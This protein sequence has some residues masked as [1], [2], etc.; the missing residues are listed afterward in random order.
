MPYRDARDRARESRKEYGGGL[1]STPSL[2]WDDFVFVSYFAPVFFCSA[3]DF[4]ICFVITLS[5]SFSLFWFSLLYFVLFIS[6]RERIDWLFYLRPKIITNNRKHKE[7]WRRGEVYQKII[8]KSPFSSSIFLFIYFKNSRSI[9]LFYFRECVF[10]GIKFDAPN[11]CSRYMSTSFPVDISALSSSS[12]LRSIRNRS[13]EWMLGGIKR[14]LIGPPY[15]NEWNSERGDLWTHRRSWP[16]PVPHKI[17]FD[18][19]SSLRMIEL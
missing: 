3:A 14:N 16:V 6:Q 15:T 19:R 7:Q 10:H 5:F 4:D 17:P 18:H 8:K 1:L 13:T 11:N 9:I 2:M 12:S